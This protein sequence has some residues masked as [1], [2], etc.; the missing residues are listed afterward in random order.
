M[1]TNA[2]LPAGAILRATT[3][4]DLDQVLALY[5]QTFPEE[6]LRP[7]VTALMSGDDDI[8]SL[9]ISFKDEVIAH[10]IFTLCSVQQSRPKDALLGP[11][12]VIPS[13]QGQ[14][15]GGM[16]VR[17]GIERLAQAGLN[18]LFVLGDPGYYGRFGFD[19]ERAV[20]PPYDLPEDWKDAW[21][22]LL[23]TPAAK[24]G[25]GRLQVPDPWIHRDL[26]VE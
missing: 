21:Q 22:S 6:E 20:V 13:Y 11:L 10:V 2:T 9:A 26:W 8:L 15:L 19:P 14:G 23:L 12:G 3:H 24:P 5:P 1:M 18:Q 17:E 7:V 25:A 16:I 4:Q